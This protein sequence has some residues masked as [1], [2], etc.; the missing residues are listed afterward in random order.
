[1]FTQGHFSYKL[2][3]ALN[4]DEHWF[5]DSSC[6]LTNVLLSEERMPLPNEIATNVEVSLII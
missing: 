6:G 4:Q 3:A 5:I 2:K 1:L